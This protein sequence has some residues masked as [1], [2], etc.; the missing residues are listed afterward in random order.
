ML[1]GCVSLDYYEA[2]REAYEKAQ[3]RS[4]AARS[5][6]TQLQK[7][8]AEMKFGDGAMPVADGDLS[9]QENG[10]LLARRLEAIQSQ[11]RTKEEER[12]I[13][14][15][16]L[17]EAR[18]SLT[19]KDQQMKTALQDLKASLKEE[20]DK[21][22]GSVAGNEHAVSVMLAE[23]ILYDSGSAEIRPEGLKVL[24]RISDALR[25]SPATYIRVEGHTDDVRIRSQPPPRFLTNFELSYARAIG[26]VKYL[27][28][29]NGVDPWRLSAM[30]LA[31]TRPLVPNTNDDVR[32]RNRRVEIV[33]TPSR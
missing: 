27:K 33:V 5:E 1:L 19:A 13:L 16:Q 18:T 8:V 30:G 10:E 25:G 9:A 29:L 21:G 4:L 20:I 22:S 11:L 23:R 7:E 28:E 24:K 3:G 31:G 15:R 32:A 17:E 14:D 2:L 26:V 6:L 12:E